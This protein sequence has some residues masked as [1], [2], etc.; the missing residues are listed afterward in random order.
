[1]TPQVLDNKPCTSGYINLKLKF[2]Q[3]EVGLWDSVNE[4]IGV[5]GGM[6]FMGLALP[7][8]E[9]LCWEVW[10]SLCVDWSTSY[11]NQSIH[12]RFQIFNR[13]FETN[14]AECGERLRLPHGRVWTVRHE[15]FNV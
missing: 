5:E 11:Q 10:S 12:I 6:E 9:H 13:D 14:L 7:V 3:Y 4:L 15:N 1:M 2:F 8:Y